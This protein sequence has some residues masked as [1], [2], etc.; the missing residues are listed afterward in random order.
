MNRNLIIILRTY[1]ANHMPGTQTELYKFRT[2]YEVYRPYKDYI[3]AA[4]KATGHPA[5]ELT[6]IAKNV[7]LYGSL[8]DDDAPALELPPIDLN[9]WGRIALA[10]RK[11]MPK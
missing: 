3:K 9:I 1:K 2:P 5:E 10:G 8:A 7:W 11:L 4:E 6:V